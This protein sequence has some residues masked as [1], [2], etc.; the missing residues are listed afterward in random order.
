[1]DHTTKD[2][3]FM[4]WTSRTGA[5]HWSDPHASSTGATS[6]PPE[7]EERLRKYFSEHAKDAKPLFD[8]ADFD[9]TVREARSP[10]AKTE[11]KRVVDPV[12]NA[13]SYVNNDAFYHNK[14][15]DE[16]GDLGQQI[17]VN[18]YLR[19]NTAVKPVDVRQS[20]LD[21]A[22]IRAQLGWLNYMDINKPVTMVTGTPALLQS[23]T[24]HNANNAFKC[25]AN[26][27]SSWMAAPNQT[28]PRGNLMPTSFTSGYIHRPVP[29]SP[30]EQPDQR[31]VKT[32]VDVPYFIDLIP[33]AWN[34]MNKALGGDKDH[35]P[36]MVLTA[37]A[38]GMLLVFPIFK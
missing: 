12:L 4:G 28:V 5:L 20:A 3:K 17:A 31:N 27:M 6:V 11:N 10:P 16:A 13:Y 19:D 29:W 2:N 8:K 7:E 30:S 32:T 34:S 26:D 21:K 33:T 37:A 1:M 35:T 24:K 25:I 38:V 15:L 18:T 14:Q 23:V 9:K 36:M 22:T